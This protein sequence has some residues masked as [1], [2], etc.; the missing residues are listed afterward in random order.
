MCTEYLYIIYDENE[1]DYNVDFTN[2][3]NIGNLHANEFFIGTVHRV[4]HLPIY[5]LGQSQHTHITFQGTC[6][7]TLVFGAVSCVKKAR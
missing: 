4:A 5:I 2:L 1:D 6:T 3:T 7:C